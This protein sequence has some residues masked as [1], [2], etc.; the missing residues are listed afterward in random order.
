MPL[1]R[2]KIPSSQILSQ[3]S[4]ALLTFQE[5]FVQTAL[6]MRPLDAHH[7]CPDFGPKPQ[8]GRAQMTRRSGAAGT[9]GEP[10]P[11]RRGSWLA[12]S[13][14]ASFS[15]KPRGGGGVWRRRTPHRDPDTPRDG[16]TSR[17]QFPQARLV[18]GRASLL[19]QVSQGPVSCRA[20][21]Q[22][23]PRATCADASPWR[24]SASPGTGHQGPHSAPCGRP[25]G[26]PSVDGCTEVCRSP[27]ECRVR[28]RPAY[29]PCL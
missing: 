16:R 13:F 2:S 15:R 8:S 11:G 12:V 18:S 19:P 14:R 24:S 5:T 6:R 26:K 4:I 28:A 20:P 3:P 9:F 29:C 22:R 21:S 23:E 1:E 25:V 10:K 27:K 17:E 7:H